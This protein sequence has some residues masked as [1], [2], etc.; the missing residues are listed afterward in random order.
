MPKFVIERDIEGI[1]NIPPDELRRAAQTSNDALGQLG[2][3]IQWLESFVT[4]NKTYCVYISPNEELIR[5]HA[6]RAG[7]PANRIVE[8]KSVIDPTTAGL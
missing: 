4:E 1:G 8:I 3:E 6:A 5:E 7:L 2:P